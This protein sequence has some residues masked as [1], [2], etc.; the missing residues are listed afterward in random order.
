[1][2]GF[3][4]S[5][6]QDSL[7]VS[8]G[9]ARRSALPCCWMSC[10]HQKYPNKRH[11]RSYGHGCQPISSQVSCVH[12]MRVRKSWCVYMCS[13]MA[14]MA[15]VFFRTGCPCGV[16]GG[17]FFG[18]LALALT[19]LCI[20]HFVDGSLRKLYPE[21][22]F[23][24]ADIPDQAGKYALITGATSGI[25]KAIATE[26]AR[27]GAHVLVGARD[28][29]RA[30]D[31]VADIIG[32]TGASPALVEPLIID[33]GSLASVKA[34]ADL[35]NAK[36]CVMTDALSNDAPTSAS[37]LLYIDATSVC[38]PAFK[39]EYLHHAVCACMVGRAAGLRFTR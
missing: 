34:A 20:Q 16:A 1:M 12:G 38:S 22:Q 23:S 37:F 10:R 39:P 8:A 26:L 9:S 35:V 31:A 2:G 28:E 15:S 18:L 25:G 13:T 11:R 33:L 14:L 29:A 7:A 36:E 4:C 17:L 24:L 5:H 27:R 3:A 21:P 19:L 30:Q 32:E 6:R